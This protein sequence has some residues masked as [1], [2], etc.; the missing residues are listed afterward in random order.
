MDDVLIS[1]PANVVKAKT[2]RVEDKY[3]LR[4]IV[5]GHDSF[6]NFRLTIMQH[7]EMFIQIYADEKLKLLEAFPIDIHRNKMTYDD[8]NLIELHLFQSVNCSI[9]FI[10]IA[11]SIRAYVNFIQYEF[12]TRYIPRMV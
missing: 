1:G 3:E 12:E 6:L 11:A 5:H 2:E 4:V 9:A 8:L 10:G 7:S